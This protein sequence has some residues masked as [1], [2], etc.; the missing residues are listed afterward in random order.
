MTRTLTKLFVLLTVYL[1]GNADAEADVRKYSINTVLESLQSPWSLAFLPNGDYLITEVSGRLLRINKQSLTKQTISNVPKVY[2]AGQGGLLDVMLD[3]DFADNQRVYL[4]FSHGSSK[5]NAT[6]LIGATLKENALINIDILFTATPF[7]KRA[8]HYGG[9]MIQTPEGHIVLGVGDGSRY[10]DQAQQ[11]DSHLGKIVRINPNG[12]V[13]HD[14]PWVEAEGALPEIWSM[15]HRNPQAIVL[16]NDGTVYAHEHGPRGGDEVNVIKPGN[17]YGWPVL[18]RGREYNGATISTLT[19]KEGMQLPLVDWTPSIAPSGM[20]IYYG[21]EFPAWEGDLLAV[22]LKQKSVRRIDLDASG[23]KVRSDTRAF[24]EVNQRL[25]DIRTGP[26]G[27]IYILTDGDNG[28]L[29]RVSAA[30]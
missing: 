23:I 4:T 24:P 16:A 11:L 17:N 7:K 20:T 28:K 29:L 5:A 3:R 27:A 9:R 21:D 19:E 8:Y 22:S 18:T 26:D 13:P 2:H 15:G 30:K 25:R 1:C 12:T 10:R 6:R 14:N